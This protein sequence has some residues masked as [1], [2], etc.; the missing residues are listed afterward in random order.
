[1]MR[2]EFGIISACI[3]VY[4][5]LSDQNYVYSSEIIKLHSQI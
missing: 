1:M 4:E 5:I 3:Y 2:T